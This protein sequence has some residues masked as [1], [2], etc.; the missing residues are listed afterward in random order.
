MLTV[1]DIMTRSVV[2]IRCSATIENAIWLMRAKQVRSLIV[3][4][5]YEDGPYGIITE[6]DIVYGVTALGKNPQHIFVG[7]LMRQPCINIPS[8]ISIEQAAK[9]LADAAIHRAPVI[10]RN[11]LLGILSVTD[12]LIKGSLDTPEED[13]LSVNIKAAL[14]QARI[15]DNEEAQ[16]RQECD[17]A[18]QVYEEMKPK[19][20]ISV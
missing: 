12:I 18:W 11:K 6:K 13:Q 10:E 17:L 9:L 20:P 7:S 4:K 2:V 16:I 5:A 15:I 3:E 14:Q 19:A 1:Q 8:H